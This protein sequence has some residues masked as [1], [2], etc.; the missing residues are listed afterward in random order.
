MWGFG[1]A[2][3]L[4]DSLKLTF[5]TIDYDDDGGVLTMPQSETLRLHQLII[6]ALLLDQLGVRSLLHHLALV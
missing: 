2:Q 5:S 3:L 1:V 6:S 4:L